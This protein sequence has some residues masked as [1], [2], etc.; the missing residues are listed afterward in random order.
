M[1]IQG[2]EVAVGDGQERGRLMWG[3]AARGPG[4]GTHW[5]SPLPRRQ[6]RQEERS[7]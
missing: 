6:P 5:G 1:R 2:T 4:L 7:A 3:G